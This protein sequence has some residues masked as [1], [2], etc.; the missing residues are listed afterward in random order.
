M[1]EQKS[2]KYRI[3]ARARDFTHLLAKSGGG[4]REAV[5]EQQKPARTAP[6]QGLGIAQIHGQNLAEVSCDRAKSL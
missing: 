1:I 2:C 5:T 4:S 3:K 6:M